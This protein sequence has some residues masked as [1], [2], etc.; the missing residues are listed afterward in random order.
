MSDSNNLK[1]NTDF[2]LYDWILSSFRYE[3]FNL[4][5]NKTKPENHKHTHI[6]NKQTNKSLKN[7]TKH[8]FI[9]VQ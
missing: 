4:K 6:K 8:E 7:E 9:S 2:F 5:Q 3:Y 1:D